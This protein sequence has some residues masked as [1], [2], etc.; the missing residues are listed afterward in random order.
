MGPLGGPKFNLSQ[1]YRAGKEHKTLFLQAMPVGSEEDRTESSFSELGRA[2]LENGCQWWRQFLVG[3]LPMLQGPRRKHREGGVN[4]SLGNRVMRR[5]SGGF[6]DVSQ[7]KRWPH[8]RKAMTGLLHE[9][10]FHG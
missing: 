1:T 4:E 5:K 7:E 9:R 3:I 2:H 8:G 6:R 10:D